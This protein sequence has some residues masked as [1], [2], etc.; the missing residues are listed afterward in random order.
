M[1]EVNFGHRIMWNF[2][3]WLVD[4]HGLPV[5]RAR[6]NQRVFSLENHIRRLLDIEDLVNISSDDLDGETHP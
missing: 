4:R 2:E 1:S 5:V 3:K 6:S